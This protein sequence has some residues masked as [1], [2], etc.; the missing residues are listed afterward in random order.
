MR[1]KRLNLRK[2]P[3]LQPNNI[4]PLNIWQILFH[5][6]QLELA[7]SDKTKAVMIAHT[8]G[9]PFDLKA[10]KAFCDKHSLW[11]VEDNCDALGSY[12][13]SSP[14]LSYRTMPIP[15]A[16]HQYCIVG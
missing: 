8:L 9:N 1:K 3:N 5:V 2:T 4:L 13:Q 12:A 15:T 11:L 16:L 7:L 14:P 6:T 10:V